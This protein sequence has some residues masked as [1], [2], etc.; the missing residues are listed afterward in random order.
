MMWRVRGPDL[1]EDGILLVRGV[2]VSSLASFKALNV[3]VH[4]YVE[5]NT[6]WLIDKS[7][8]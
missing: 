4:L 3:V 1:T 2:V 7:Q 6:L 5:T 8:L